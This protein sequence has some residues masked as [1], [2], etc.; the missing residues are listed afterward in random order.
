LPPCPNRCARIELL[1]RQLCEVA[2]SELLQEQ[3]E[4]RRLRGEL[5][6]LR[7]T[8]D[9]S[10]AERDKA[11]GKELQAWKD[12]LAAQQREV[13]CANLTPHADCITVPSGAWLPLT[14]V[15]PS[16]LDAV[17]ERARK[18]E[19]GESQSGIRVRK[20]GDEVAGEGRKLE[21][22]LQNA[23]LQAPL[24]PLTPQAV[25]HQPCPPLLCTSQRRLYVAAR[26]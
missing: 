19:H 14:W 22:A 12:K 1:P 3:E 15:S 10:G 13:P 9:A 4:S 18:A 2:R 5:T 17:A 8:Y 26:A 23:Q 20:L 24:P 11:K 6:A 25:P 7:S 16:Q 21:T